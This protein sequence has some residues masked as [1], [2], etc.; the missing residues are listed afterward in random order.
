MGW[1]PLP[2]EQ[3]TLAQI[4][5]GNGFHTAA[6]VDTPFYVRGG[7]NYDRGFET[8]FMYSGQE[9]SGTRVQQRGHH[10]SR[11]LVASWRNESDRNAPQTFTRAM[12]W[13]EQH[14]KEDFFLYID[15][16]DPHEPWDA[17]AYYTE[18]YLPG[19]EG[20]IVQPSVL[21]NLWDIIPFIV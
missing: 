3:T 2:E 4:L 7:M 21:A 19:Y 13:L 10:E 1:E 9:G 6:V 20:G 16:W 14:Y 18:P 15:T 17:P 8:F 12:R 11:D 5:A